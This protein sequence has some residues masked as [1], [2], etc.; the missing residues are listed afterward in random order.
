MTM[1]TESVA[2]LKRTGSEL[3]NT[4][5]TDITVISVNDDSL[6]TSDMSSVLTGRTNSCVLSCLS[7]L[8][9]RFYSQ[10]VGT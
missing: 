8:V 5:V 2:G 1:K 4:P 10:E 9:H 6:S 7:C 3:T